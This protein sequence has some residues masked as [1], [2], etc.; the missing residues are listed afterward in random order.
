MIQR[1]LELVARSLDRIVHVI[2]F[3]AY[4][5]RLMTGVSLWDVGV[6]RQVQLKGPDAARLAQVLC[7]RDLQRFEAN[8]GSAATSNGDAVTQ[9]PL[10]EQHS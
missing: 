3:M 1:V 10:I 5:Y 6:E 4:G 7:V 8:L 2:A 9:I